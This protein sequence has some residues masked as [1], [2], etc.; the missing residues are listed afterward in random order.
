MVHD[1]PLKDIPAQDQAA[2]PQRHRLDCLADWKA[3]WLSA[4]L[5]TSVNAGVILMVTVTLGR[6][7]S[8]SSP[9]FWDLAGPRH[10]LS[11]NPLREQPHYKN[12]YIFNF[13]FKKFWLYLMRVSPQILFQ[14]LGKLHSL[15]LYQNDL[16]YRP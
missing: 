3:K 9:T 5:P 11:C 10:Y 1:S 7:Q 12:T 6:L 14:L 4:S 15:C 8:Q 2:L 16:S 13:I